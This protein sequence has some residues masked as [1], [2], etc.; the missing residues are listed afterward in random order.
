M[1]G[2][3]QQ[4]ALVLLKNGIIAGIGKSAKPYNHE[5]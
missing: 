4:H 1:H 3:Q 2:S 5:L